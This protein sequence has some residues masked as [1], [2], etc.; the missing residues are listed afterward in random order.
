MT[1]TRR[2]A[3]AAAGLLLAGAAPARPRV[4]SLN[5]CLDAILVRVADRAQIAALS[6]YA[7]DPSQSGIA[8]LAATLPCT[9][10]TA[11]E[12][13]ALRPDLVVASLHSSPATRAAL[14]RLGIRQAVFSVPETVA[15]SLDQVRRLAALVGHPDRG[16]ALAAAITAALARAAPPPGFGPVSALVVAPD[17]LAAGEG[18]LVDDMLRR[19]GF[20]NA[21][22][23]YGLAKW[24]SAPLEALLADPPKILLSASAGPASDGGRFLRRP[25]LAALRGRVIQAAFPERLLYCGGPTLIET[26]AALAAAR[27][28]LAKAGG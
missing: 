21:A 26:A 18:T 6:H 22:R 5:P 16:E 8:A 12:I 9:H 15:A 25:A 2:A 1:A 23:R 17:G 28:R 20:V 11:E 27:D 19:T 4:V 24:D 3:I 7:R 14:D 13:V 10:E